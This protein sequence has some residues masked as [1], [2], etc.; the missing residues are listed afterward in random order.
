M[1]HN[2]NLPPVLNKDCPIGTECYRR[3]MQKC[4]L[5]TVVQNS[6]FPK[7]YIRPQYVCPLFLHKA[8]VQHPSSCIQPCAWTWAVGTWVVRTEDMVLP[9]FHIVNTKHFR[10]IRTQHAC[11]FKPCLEFVVGSQIHDDGK[12]LM[13]LKS[14]NLSSFAEQC[15]KPKAPHKVWDTRDIRMVALVVR[16]F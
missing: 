3:H 7:F 5:A 15:A 6:N 12:Y 1:C 10:P 2:I 14:E 4:M 8:S 11:S 13:Q 9:F 16:F